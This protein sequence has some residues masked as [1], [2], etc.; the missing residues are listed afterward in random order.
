MG[1]VW[2]MGQGNSYFLN[3][4]YCYPGTSVEV[5]MIALGK[6]II[7]LHNN[8]DSPLTDAEIERRRGVALSNQT[9]QDPQTTQKYA[10]YISHRLD[11]LRIAGITFNASIIEKAPQDPAKWSSEDDRR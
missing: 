3:D 4:K 1:A 8:E 7:I 2:S 6:W 9:W 11:W 5:K 10:L